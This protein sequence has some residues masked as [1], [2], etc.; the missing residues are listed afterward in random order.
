LASASLQAI[1]PFLSE[2]DNL[3]QAV[4]LRGNIPDT[5][6]HNPYPIYQEIA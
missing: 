5:A 3:S 6:L 4:M 1:F 2:I